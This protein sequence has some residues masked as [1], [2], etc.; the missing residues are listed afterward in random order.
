MLTITSIQKR[1]G[2]SIWE[3]EKVKMGW[4]KLSRARISYKLGKNLTWGQKLYWD[5]EK[6]KWGRKK[7]KEV[8][9]K[10]MR[11]GKSY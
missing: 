11:D 7:V 9:K 1:V 8:G 4:V 10:F 2:E 5:R 6:L 3:T